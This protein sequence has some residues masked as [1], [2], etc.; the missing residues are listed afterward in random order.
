MTLEIYEVESSV[1][2]RFKDFMKKAL[3]F[4]SKF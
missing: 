1:Y 2:K 3:P 4:L